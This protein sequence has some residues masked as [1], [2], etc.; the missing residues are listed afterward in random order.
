MSFCGFFR[1][2][3]RLFG[4]IRDEMFPVFA[5]PRVKLND[6]RQSVAGPFEFT[7]DLPVPPIH[8]CLDDG[9]VEL[10]NHM[11]KLVEGAGRWAM[12]G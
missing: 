4:A 5:V 10:G 8:L 6:I 3:P 2:G 9:K 7:L 12:R 11:L 1:D